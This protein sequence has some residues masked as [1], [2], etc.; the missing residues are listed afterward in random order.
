[1]DA[2]ERSGKLVAELSNVSKH[3]GER[4]VDRQ[5]FLPHPAR[6]QDRPARPERQRAKARCSRSSW[7]NC[8]RTSG[9]CKLGTKLSVAYFDQLR[10]QLNEEATLADT[11]SQGS[12]FVEIGGEQQ[13]RDQLS[14]RLPVRAGARALAGQIACPAA[15]A[16]ACCWRACSP[17]RP[18]CWCWT[19]RPT[20][21]TSRRWS[22][23]RSCWPIRRHPVSGQ[24][25]PRVSRQRRH[26]DDRLR[27]R[28]ALEGVRRRL[29]R[30]AAR[31]V[32]GEPRQRLR[33][34]GK[35]RRSAKKADSG[36]TGTGQ[37][38]D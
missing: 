1:M 14:R 10:A 6:R 8:S 34:A 17:G 2:G 12:D 13:A 16:T 26:A 3:F 21:S 33:G 20:I 30:L 4:K 18:T 5:F 15:S 29:H 27:G 37:A 38:P 32:L 11:I 31:E 7:A 36:R 22:C 35:E 25:R 23:W 28:R 19:S 24:P 9:R